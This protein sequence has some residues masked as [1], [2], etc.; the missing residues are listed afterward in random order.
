MLLKGRVKP[1]APKVRRGS[2]I[3]PLTPALPN[4]SS[5]GEGIR[6]GGNGGTSKMRPGASFAEAR[7]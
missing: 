1:Q 3:F 4:P 6:S 2:V 5:W 7:N